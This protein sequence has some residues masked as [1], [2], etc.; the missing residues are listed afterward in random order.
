MYLF[1]TDTISNL[2]RRSPSETLVAKLARTPLEQQ[3]VSSITVGEL[4]YGVYRSPQHAARLRRWLDA[5]LFP[6]IQKLPFDEAAA[7]VHGELRATLE[8]LGTPIGD[9]D[10]RIAAI[11]LERRLT[12]VTGNVRHFRRVP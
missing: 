2:S 10:T 1:D 4:V 8:R 7:R 11:V 9:A 12:V 5:K 3:F 6:N